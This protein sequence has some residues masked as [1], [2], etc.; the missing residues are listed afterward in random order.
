M[1]GQDIDDIVAGLLQDADATQW[2]AED[3]L[4]W[5]NAGVRD[6]ATHKPKATTVSQNILLTAA[7]TRQAVPADTIAVLDLVCNMGES[8]TVPG[9]HIT[10]VS[11]DRL[12]ASRPSWRR[13][14]ATYVRHLVMDDRD[15]G[16][17]YVWPAPSAASY[18]EALLHKHP[19]AI[20][21]LSQ[22]LPLD[23]SYQNALVDFV[24]HMAFSQE[25]EMPE[26]L[27]LAAA[28][29][30]KYAQTLGL[31]VQRQKKAS[32]PANTAENPTHP[33]VDKNGA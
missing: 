23:N 21:A 32:A 3:R 5:I 4:R 29:Y 7:S 33:V 30:A 10:A 11:A 12:G 19:A 13:D 27:T 26:R 15:P 9:R 16:A 20:A 31:Q 2:S 17:F 1:T 18:V 28:H 8:G 14:K 6:I 22:T 24:M 25:A